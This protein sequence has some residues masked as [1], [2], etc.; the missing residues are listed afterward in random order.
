[1]PFII[2]EL[3]RRVINDYWERKTPARTWHQGPAPETA[4]SVE[5]PFSEEE[6]Y[7]ALGITAAS[8]TMAGLGAWLAVLA[9]RRWGPKL[10]AWIRQIRRPRRL[11]WDS[12]SLAS[13][14]SSRGSSSSAST[15]SGRPTWSDRSRPGRSA[16]GRPRSSGKSGSGWTARSSSPVEGTKRSRSRSPTP[17]PRAAAGRKCS[18]AKN[19]GR[20]QRDRAAGDAAGPD[21]SGRRARSAPRSLRRRSGSPSGSLDWT[22]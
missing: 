6:I 2:Y 5:L 11:S 16:N 3:A 22:L 10:L 1:M 13:V 8:A 20:G 12:E 18:K 4:V 9:A 19:G 7:Q 15:T 14:R 17:H 21:T